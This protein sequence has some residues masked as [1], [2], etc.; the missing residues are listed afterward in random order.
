MDM[1]FPA[2]LSRSKAESK[3]TPISSD[4]ARVRQGEFVLVS[5]ATEISRRSASR[6]IAQYSCL[7]LSKKDAWQN[8][9]MLSRHS[10]RSPECRMA[11]NFLEWGDRFA[12][13]KGGLVRHSPL[14][15]G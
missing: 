7:G 13:S 4:K 8:Q 14:S 12:V 6:E 3:P 9:T 10:G 15:V 11:A 5:T 1:T 2:E